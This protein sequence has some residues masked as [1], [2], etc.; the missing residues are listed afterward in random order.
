MTEQQPDRNTDD[1]PT[2]ED[3]RGAIDPDQPDSEQLP[4]P[5]DPDDP[6][7]PSIDT[8]PDARIDPSGTNPVATTE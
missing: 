4:E 1:D 2:E 7:N 6:D 8:D 3:Q 5:I